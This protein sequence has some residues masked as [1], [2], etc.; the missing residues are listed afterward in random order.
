MASVIPN[1][2]LVGHKQADKIKY[3]GDYSYTKLPNGSF[4]CD[5]CDYVTNGPLKSVLG[6]VR[7]KHASKW[8]IEK[9]YAKPSSFWR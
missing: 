4:K 2:K 5:S 3:L 9:D 7:M 6:H 1:K 8:E